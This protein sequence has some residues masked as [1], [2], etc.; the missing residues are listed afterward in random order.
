MLISEMSVQTRA[1]LPTSSPIRTP[2]VD[3]SS[4]RARPCGASV[5]QIADL[6]LR[7]ELAAP[8]TGK[9]SYLN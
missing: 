6:P 2:R 8:L 7:P 3:K 5:A 4:A 1:T 9:D